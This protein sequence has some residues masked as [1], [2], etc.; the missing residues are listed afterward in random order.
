MSERKRSDLAPLQANANRW[1]RP[2]KPV[3]AIVMNT[4]SAEGHRPSNKAPKQMEFG[5]SRTE[6]GAEDYFRHTIGF[7]DADIFAGRS[8]KNEVRQSRCG[9]NC[10]LRGARGVRPLAVL[11]V[12]RRLIVELRGTLVGWGFVTG[13]GAVFIF[14]YFDKALAG[15]EEF[16]IGFAG[17]AKAIFGDDYFKRA[18]LR[19]GFARRRGRFLDEGKSPRRHLARPS[20]NHEGQTPWAAVAARLFRFR[21]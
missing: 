20:P 16:H 11:I 21:G 8:P 4:R 9:V 6:H 10:P 12:R 19:A 7:A 3:R 18:P 5:K 2:T 1:P 17:G 14:G 15:G 13:G